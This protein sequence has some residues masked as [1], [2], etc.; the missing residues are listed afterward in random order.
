MT[1]RYL[2]RSEFLALLADSHAALAGRARAAL[3]PEDVE[4]VPV[5]SGSVDLPTYEARLA[6]ADAGE[7]PMTV[8]LRDFVQALKRPVRQPETT[9]FRGTDGTHFIVLL[10]CGQVV[11]ITTIE[12][13]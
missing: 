12:A 2:D 1:T 6:R 10:D 8:G 4:K 13:S 5:A 7:G 3:D 9:G 11:A